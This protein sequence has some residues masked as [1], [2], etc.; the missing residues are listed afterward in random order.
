MWPYLAFVDAKVSLLSSCC[1]LPC[2][3]SIAAP[4]APVSIGSPKGVPVPCT[5]S[6][7]IAGSSADEELKADRISSC[8]AGPFG[9]VREEDLPS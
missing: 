5:A 9:A 6:K 1:C 8:C 4:I 3:L 7:L 2:I